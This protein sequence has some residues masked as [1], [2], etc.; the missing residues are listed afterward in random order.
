MKTDWKIASDK[1]MDVLWMVQSVYKIP[2]WMDPPD[3]KL[4]SV[5]RDYFYKELKERSKDGK[6]HTKDKPNN[7]K[8]QK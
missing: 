8:H 5:L 3:G 1:A 2:F 7:E 4:H 6:V